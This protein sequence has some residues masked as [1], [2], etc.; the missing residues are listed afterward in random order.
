MTELPQGAV[1]DTRDSVP[2]QTRSSLPPPSAQRKLVKHAS[3]YSIASLLSV[4]AGLVTFPLLTRVFSVHDYGVLSL[5]SATLGIAVAIGKTGLQH[6]IVRYFSEISAKKSEF[7]L[8]QLYSTAIIG[9]LVSALVTMAVMALGA[10]FVPSTWIE[11]TRFRALLVIVAVLGV[12]QVLDSVMSN[13]LVADQNSSAQL[14]YQF[15]KKYLG[16]GAIVVAVLLIAPTLTAF[17]WAKVVAEGI[18]LGLPIYFL[19]AARSDL[20]PRLQNFSRPLYAKLLAYGIPMVIGYELS[21]I[22][23]NVGDRY[24]IDAMMGET[25][26]GLYS[27]AYSLSQYVQSIFISSIGQAIMPIYMRMW[28]EKGPEE[29]VKFISDSLRSYVLVS[30]PVIAGLASVGPE[31]LPSL[32]SEKYASA[33]GVLPWLSS[34]MIVDG[35]ASFLGAGLFVHRKSRVVAVIVFASAV[36][37][38]AFNLV[39]V[40]RLGVLG[41]AIAT[42]GSYALLCV[43]FAWRGKPLLDVKVP[44]ATIVRASLVGV[45]MYAAL[46]YVLPGRRFITVGVRAALGG[47]IYVGLITL[48]DRDARKLVKMFAGK[49]RQ[50]LGRA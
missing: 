28:D 16:L 15:A 27:A 45:V 17:W 21:G 4:I 3:H 44:W 18:A 48:L 33:A 25:D 9:M 36:A 19:F 43:G 30:A 20:R 6:A 40:P 8:P 47:A 1:N 7:T 29:T 50:R 22:V 49:L 10:H 32:A 26:L 13:F 38:I 12:I 11:D 46:H 41:A 2:P 35:A 31:L 5:L 24:I 37:N 34:G 23:L 39:L 42:L 14:K